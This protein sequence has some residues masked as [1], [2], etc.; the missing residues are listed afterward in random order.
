VAV[1][2]TQLK[3]YAF[4]CFY[5]LFIACNSL[6]YEVTADIYLDPVSVNFLVFWECTDMEAN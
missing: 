6:L 1:T 3:Y 2:I 4:I 5:S